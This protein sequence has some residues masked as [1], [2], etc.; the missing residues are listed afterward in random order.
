MLKFINFCYP[1]L[2]LH[3]NSLFF[4]LLDVAPF[5]FYGIVLTET[6]IGHQDIVLSVYDL[7]SLINL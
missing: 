5:C 6:A 3:H 1:C 7:K 2:L 4:M